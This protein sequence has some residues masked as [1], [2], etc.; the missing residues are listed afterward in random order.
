MTTSSPSPHTIYHIELR[1]AVLI[2]AEAW[3]VDKA[4]KLSLHVNVNDFKTFATNVSSA[5]WMWVGTFE[6]LL[7]YTYED[8]T[9]DWAT[10]RVT[11]ECKRHWDTSLWSPATWFSAQADVVATGQFELHDLLA[12]LTSSAPKQTVPLSVKLLHA[13]TSTHLC[14]VRLSLDLTLSL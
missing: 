5:P 6:K 3:T 9:F 2:P 1:D 4:H 11:I 7:Y 14:T 10:K 8:S 13:T 12:K